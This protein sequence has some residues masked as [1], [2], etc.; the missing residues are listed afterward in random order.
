LTFAEKEY[1]KI[2]A[3]HS[4]EDEL[5]ELEIPVICT[6][7]VENWLNTLLV[8]H[9]QSVGA[10]IALGLQ[11]MIDPEFDIL[12]LI[13]DSIL[14]VRRRRESHRASRRSFLHSLPAGF[15]VGIASSVDARLR[16]GDDN[17]ETR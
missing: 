12:L 2:I 9:Q 17:V 4:R 6:G 10:V 5:I 8:A 11:T 15:L 16:K 1:E 3:M 14:Q 13:E 7:G